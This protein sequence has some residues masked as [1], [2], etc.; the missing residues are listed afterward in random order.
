MP[1]LRPRP[2]RRVPEGLF[3]PV[4]RGERLALESERGAASQAEPAKVPG[5]A[6][7]ARHILGGERAQFGFARVAPES[8][9]VTSRT[10]SGAA[11]WQEGWLQRVCNW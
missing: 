1:P 3:R 6:A 2:P 5:Q 7:K 4:E 9:G 8:T 11:Q 10:P